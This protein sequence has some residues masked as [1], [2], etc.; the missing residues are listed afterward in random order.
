MNKNKEQ[1]F[2]II[3]FFLIVFIFCKVGVISPNNIIVSILSQ[4]SSTGNVPQDIVEYLS[5]ALF[6]ILVFLRT[7][8]KGNLIITKQIYFYFLFM[9]FSSL[10]Y[11][12]SLSKPFAINSIVSVV[13]LWITLLTLTNYI[14]SKEKLIKV[15]KYVVISNILVAFKILLLY[16]VQ[17]GSAAVRIKSI[18]GI[19]FN[20]VGQ[21][22]G[23]SV[24][25]SIYL[26]KYT[27]N[28]KYLYSI[29]PQFMAI[30]LMESRKSLLIP[31]LG[32]F[33]FLVLQRNVAK[34]LKYS[35]IAIL[36]GGVLI[37]SVS[38]VSPSTYQNITREMGELIKY[39]R[40]E[41]TD[42]WSINLR[43]FFIETGKDVFIENP[44]KGIGLNNFAYYVGHYT[45]YNV[46][47][48]SHNNY[49][50][51]LSCL[52]IIGFILYYSSYVYCLIKLTKNVLSNKKDSLSI[53]ALSFL[54][55]LIIMEW[56]VISYS[57]CLY[58]IYILFIY[59]TIIY[60]KE[61]QLKA[62]NEYEK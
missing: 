7:I 51:M 38:K 49:I 22:L 34:L 31:I 43:S 6:V 41:T 2:N 18:T 59:Y 14:D 3:D 44:I 19:Y 62:G 9:V 47:R 40:G 53:V 35:F 45:S 37:F 28:K 46:E 20:T 10:S 11:F 1:K 60:Q 33:L 57:G 26:Y 8:K 29:V 16:W 54:I 13:A 39:S 55:V 17:S 12:W 15:M 61:L 50:E 48:Y 30:V 23:F 27:N 32:I 24:L 21:V 42:D 56:G 36:L 5:L 25:F 58:H 4:F 52:G